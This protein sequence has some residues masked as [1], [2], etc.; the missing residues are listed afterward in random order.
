[1]TS[2][3]TGKPSIKPYCYING[4]IERADKLYVSCYDIGL[5]RGYAIYEGI[6][7]YGDKP[8]YLKQHLARFKRSA[9]K[10]GLQIPSTDVEIEQ[11]LK[12]LI[13]KNGFERTNLKMILTGGDAI[14]GIEF[15]VNTPTFFVIAEKWT[16]LP[17]DLYI[18]G[19]KIIVE[20]H[21]RFMP[22]VKSTHY[23]TTVSL[24]VKRKKEKA[25]EILFTDKGKILECSTSNIFM[26]FGD[27]LV[28]PKD[29]VLFGIT[30]MAVLDIAKKHFKIEE[31]DVTI[32]EMK[33]ADEIFLT[34]S[35]KDI[36]PIV[37]VDKDKVGDGVVG[38]NTKVIMDL[39]SKLVKK[40]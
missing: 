34:S 1:M 4:K 5:L 22:D 18:K 28:T 36:V 31:R 37:M 2:E 10:L 12:T 33:K 13:K 21:Q 3:K 35:Y 38:K 24:Q 14:R 39:F 23:I 16:P 25:I 6:T 27:T 26:F 30:R 20:E 17:E 15:N 19:G 29:N 32:E 11:I 8:F 7:A 40:G 9:K